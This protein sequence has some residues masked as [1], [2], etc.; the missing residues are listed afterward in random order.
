MQTT[1]LLYSRSINSFL[2]VLRVTR[3]AKRRDLSIN[4]VVVVVVVVCLFVSVVLFI[5]GGVFVVVVV[6]GG[7]GLSVSVVIFRWFR[8]VVVV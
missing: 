2:V 1:R 8:F 3:I 4:S 5:F 6:G 7:G